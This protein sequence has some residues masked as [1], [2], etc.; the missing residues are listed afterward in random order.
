MESVNTM[1]INKEINKLL[2]TIETSLGNR[3]KERNQYIHNLQWE[4]H[5]QLSKL[6]EENKQL[7]DELEE[8]RKMNQKN[9]TEKEQLKK[10]F[11]LFGESHNLTC[12]QQARLQHGLLPYS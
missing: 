3:L 12:E 8:L 5:N 9:Y 4:H 1:D 6:K 11:K 7:K 2:S 10:Q